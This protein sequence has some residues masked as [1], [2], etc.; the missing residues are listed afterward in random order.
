MGARFGGVTEKLSLQKIMT[1][2]SHN[3]VRH[4]EL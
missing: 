2:G 1:V 4:E 3:P